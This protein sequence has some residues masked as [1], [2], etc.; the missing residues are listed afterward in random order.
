MEGQGWGKGVNPFDLVSE[1]TPCHLEILP[2]TR[3]LQSLRKHTLSME[4]LPVTRELQSWSGFQRRKQG[5][6]L[7][8]EGRGSKF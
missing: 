3:E 1:S 4:I 6:L 5:R 2:V 8:E 7:M